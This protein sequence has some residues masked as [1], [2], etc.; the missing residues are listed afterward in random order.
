MLSKLEESNA[1]AKLLLTV[2]LGHEHAL[3]VHQAGWDKSRIR[4]FLAEHGRVT[5]E[6]LVGSGLVPNAKAFGEF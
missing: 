6:E 3:A 2:V 1:R 4:E 5:P